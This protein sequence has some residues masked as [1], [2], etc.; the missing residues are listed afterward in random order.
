M[1]ARAPPGSP[2]PMA[3]S[4]LQNLVRQWLLDHAGQVDFAECLASALGQAGP[5]GVVNAPSIGLALEELAHQP[6]TFWAGACLCGRPGLR[7][8][9]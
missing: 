3:D 6:Q 1:R 7:Y 2:A 9:W 8:G 4:L 5:P